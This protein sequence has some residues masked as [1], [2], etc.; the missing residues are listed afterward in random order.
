MAVTNDFAAS[1]LDLNGK[2]SLTQPTALVWGPDGRLYVSENGGTINVLTVAFGDVDPSDDDNT[3]SFYVEAAVSMTLDVQ[4]HN[5]DGTLNTSVA[6]QITGLEVTAQYDSSGNQLFIDSEGDLTTEAFGNTAAVTIFV[7]SSDKRIGAGGSGNDADLDT[8]SGVITMMTQDGQNSWDQVD[9]VRGLPRSEE[10]HAS[11]GME[12]IQELDENGVLV[13]ERLLLAQGGNANTGAPSNNFA[14]Q[15]EQPLSAAILEIDVTAIK[16]MDV[17]TDDDD[18]Q[19]VYDLPTLDDPTREGT[20]D[21]NDPNG[22]NDGLNSAILQQDGIVSIYSPGYRNAYDIEVT[23]D[24]RVWTYDNGA[25]NSWGGRPHGEAGDN[26]ANVDYEQDPNYI[27]TNLNNGDGYSEDEISL[28]SN[29][30]PSN[31]DNFHE[32][33]RSDDLDGREL[34]VGGNGPVATYEGPDGLTYVYGGHPNP[35]RASGAKAGI[36]FSPEGGTTNAFLLVSDQSSYDEGTDDYEQIVAW[37]S[38]VES[39]SG[40]ASAGDLTKKVLEVTPGVLYDIYAFEDG[41][42]AAVVAGDLAPEGGTL[43]GQSGLPENIDEIVSWTNEIEGNYLEA[44]RTDGALDT[45]KGSINGLAEYTSTIM[46][47]GDIKMSGAIFASVY[48]NGDLVIMGRNEDGTMSST[49]G[50]NATAAD[51]AVYDASGVPLGLATLGDDYA[52]LGLSQAFQGSVWTAVYGGSVSIQILQP[53]NG[54]VPLA[55]AEITDPND[56]DLDGI[57]KYH[58]PFEFSADNGFLLNP[59]QKIVL[60]FDPQS[61]ENEGS[62]G[63]NTGLLGAAL[64]GPGSLAGPLADASGTD[65]MQEAGA[66]ANQDARTGTYLENAGDLLG[67]ADQADGLYDLAGNI[68]PGGNAPIL[69]IKEVVPGTMVGAGNTARDAL[70]TG[71]RPN[72]DV[73]RI[74]ATLTANNWVPAQSVAE[75]QLVGMVFGDGTQ[76]NFL[77]LVFGEVNGVPGL[78]VGYEIDDANYQAL[79]QVALEDLSLAANALIDLR[80]EIDIND[81]YAVNAFYRLGDANTLGA[82]PFTV[83]NLGGFSLPEGVLQNVLNGTHTISDGDSSALSGASI[84]VVAETSEGNPLQAI[85]FHNI[86]IEAFGNEIDA[87]SAVE[88]GQAGTTGHDQIIYSGSDT[89]LTLAADVEDFDGSGSDA[90]FSITTNDL[91]NKVVVGSGANVI[92]TGDGE[93]SIVGTLA[94]LDGDEITDFTPS[95]KLIISDA[96]TN[97]LQVAYA[98][99][100][101]I[102]TINGTTQI[103]FSGPDFEDFQVSD[104]AD[105]FSFEDSAEGLVVSTAPAL[106]PVLAINA[107][108]AE[109]SVTTGTLRD[110][111]LEFVG[112]GGGAA[113]GSFWTTPGGTKSYTNNFAQTHDYPGTDLDAILATERSNAGAFG[114][115]VDV[116]DGT[117]LIDFLFAEIYHGGAPF[118]GSGGDGS[119]V[120]DL[121]VEGEE[122]FSNID[123]H[124]EA[125]GNGT[126]LIKSVMVEITDGQLNINFPSADTD[127]AKLSGMVI[128]SV[129][130]DFEPPADTTIPEIVSIEVNNPQSVQDGERIATVT[131]EDDTGFDAAS[132][133]R[134]DGTELVF[135]GIVPETISAPVVTL[136]NG[137]T[138][139]TLTYTLTAADN[140]WTSGEGSISIAPGTFQDAA[141]NAT[142]A[143]SGAFILEPGLDTLIKGNL[144]LAINVGPTSNGTADLE[145]DNDVTYGGAI[146]GDTILGIDLEADNPDYYS[147]SSKT[148]SNIDG[149]VGNTGSN[150]ALDGS[151]LHTYRD[152]SNGSF[153]ASYPIENGI[154]VVELWFAELYHETGG[155]RQGDYTIN[156]QPWVENFDA[157]TE[158]GGADTPVMISKTV[159]VTD[160]Q[161]A[162]DMNADSGQPGWNAIV[163]Y[164]AIAP[165]TPPT[166]SV[167][168][169]TAPEGH[170]A[171]V[172]FT[173]TG[174]DSEDVMVDF[175]VTP[176]S[177]D[178]EDFGAPSILSPVTIP[179]GQS[180]VQ[181][182]IPIIDDE[183]EEGAENFSVTIMSVSNASTDALIAAGTAT[184]T[185]EPSDASLQIPQ[186]GVLYELDFETAGDPL[187][188][189]GFDTLL[190]GTGALDTSV[191]TEVIDG[192]LIVNTSNGDLSQASDTASKNDFAKTVDLSAA[193]LEEI[194]LTTRFDN[195]FPAAMEAQGVTSEVIPNYAQQGIVIAVTDPT[196][197]QD[198]DN[199]VKLVFGG[200]SG[201]GVQMWSQAVVNQL[202][203]LTTI[204]DAAATGFGLMDIASI[205]LSLLIDKGDGTIAQLVTFYNAAGDILGGTRPTETPGFALAAPQAMPDEIIASI[206]SGATLAG[207]TSTD[208]NT[209]FDSFEASWDFLQITSPQYVE[210]EDTAGP[211]ATVSLSVPDTADGAIVVNVQYIDPSDIDPSTIDATDLVL[212]GPITADAPTVV[213]D[214]VTG[215]A[216]YTFAAPEGGWTEGEYTATL[217]AGEV[218]DL[219][220]TPNVSEGGQS[221]SAELVLPASPDEYTPGDVLHAFNFGGGAIENDPILGISFDAENL[222]LI[223][224][225]GSVYEDGAAGTDATGDDASL[226]GSIYETERYA[227]N[228]SI[229]VPVANGLYFIEV[230]L[231]E[232]FQGDE[233]ARIFDVDIE[234]TQAE[235]ALDLVA[236]AGASTPYVATQLVLVE[237]GSASIQL[238][239]TEDNAKIAGLVI[240]EAV[241]VAADIEISIEGP[242]EIAEDGNGEDQAVAYTLVASD[243]AFSGDVELTLTVDGIVMAQAASFVDGS[244]DIFVSVPTDS[245]WNGSETVIVEITS[246]ETDGFAI[247]AAA[248]TASATILENDAADVYDLDGSG[249]EAPVQVGDFSDDRLNPTSIGEMQIGENILQASQQGDGQPGDRDRDFITFEIPEGMVLSALYLDAYDS[250]SD[251]NAGFMGLQKG[252]QITVDPTT[253]E[254]D[255]PYGLDAGL[256][257]GTGYLT[258]D[259]LPLLAASDPSDNQE[260]QFPGFDLPLTAGTYTLWLNQG[261]AATSVTL[262]AVVEEAPENLAPAVAFENVLASLAEN[263]DTTVPIKV[264]DIVVTDDGLGEN[265]LSLTGADADLFEIVDTGTALELHLKADV[266]LDFETLSELSVSVS[267]DDAEIGTGVE[268]SALFT[269]AITDVV[270]GAIPVETPDDLPTGGTSGDDT[271]SYSGSENVGTTEAPYQMPED[272]ENFDATGTGS[273]K[274]KGTAG[275]NTIGLGSG[276]EDEVDLSDGGNDIVTG[277]ADELNNSTISGIASDDQIVV[278]GADTNASIIRVDEGS[279]IIQID[280]DGD[281]EADTTITLEEDFAPEQVKGSFSNGTFMVTVSDRVEEPDNAISIAFEEGNLASYSNQ[282]ETPDGAEILDDGAGLGLSG[283]TWKR[284]A[285][286][287]PLTIEAGMTLSLLFAATADGEITGIGLDDDNLHDQAGMPMFQFTGSQT[288]A[289]AVQD[290]NTYTAGDGEVEMDISL[291][292]WVGKTFS[293]LVFFADD[294]A[295]EVA[296]AT[297][298]NVKI[299]LP[300]TENLAPIT[301]DDT[302]SAEVNQP[303]TID[304]LTL[305]ANDSDPEGGALTLISVTGP[306]ASEGSVELAD[307]DIVFTPALDFSGETSFAYEV[308][309]EDG[310]TSTGNVSVT[311][312]EAPTGETV[313]VS[314]ASGLVT[315]YGATQDEEPD[316]WSSSNG[317]TVI[318]LTGN[319]WKKVALP[320]IFTVS[321]DAVLRFTVSS[322]AISEIIAIG[323]EQDNNHTTG[324]QPIFQ[325]AGSQL[326]TAYASQEFND[327]TS[328]EKTYEISFSGWEGASF[329]HLVLVNDADDVTGTNVTFS[330]VALIVAG[331]SENTAPTATDDAYGSDAGSTFTVLGIELT[332]NDADPEGDALSV[333]SVQNATNGTVSIDDDVITFTPPPGFKGLASFEYTIED[334][335][336]GTSTATA[337]IDFSNEEPEAVADSLDAT[338]DVPLL[339]VPEALLANDTDAEG[340]AL[341]LTGVSNALN[342]SVA[343][344]DG[345]ITFTP[346]QGYFGPASFDYTIED[347]FGGTS[348]NTVTLLFNEVDSGPQGIT[349]V[350]FDAQNITSFDAEDLSGGATIEDDG[351]VLALAG[352]TWKKLLL[353]EPVSVTDDMVLRFTLESTN[354]GEIIAIGLGNDNVFRTR[355]DQ[356]LFQLAGSQNWAS[357]AEQDYDTYQQGQGAVTYEI[358]LA[359]WAGQSFK[360]LYF[361]NDHDAGGTANSRY[362]NVQIVQKDITNQAPVAV[363]D[364]PFQVEGGETITLLPADLLA[365]D[366]DAEGDVLGVTGIDSSENGIAVYEDGLVY[367]TPDEG[368]AGTASFTYVIADGFGGTDTATVYL[369]VNS[370]PQANTDSFETTLGE[371]LYLTPEDLLANDTDADGDALTLES[372]GGAVGGTVSL[373]DGQIVF[374]PAQGFTGSASFEYVISDPRGGISTGSVSVTVEEAEVPT[375]GAIDIDFTSMPISGYA[376]PNDVTSE[377]YTATENS[378]SLEGNTWKKVALPQPYIPDGESVLRFEFSSSE[379]GEIMGIGLEAN[380]DFNNSEQVHF[381]LAGSQNWA[382]FANQDYFGYSPEDGTVTIE[383]PLADYAGMEFTYIVFINDDDANSSAQSTFSN[384]QLTVETAD[385]APAFE[386]DPAFVL[387]ENETLVGN[388]FAAD[389]EGADILYSITGGDDAG[390]F[391]I[392]EQTGVISFDEA[393]N[394]EFPSDFDGDNVFELTVTADDGSNTTSADHTVTVEDANEAP[395]ISG[396]IEDVDLEAGEATSIDLSTLLVEDEDAGS[397]PTIRA[398][399][400]D[401]SALPS[402]ITLDGNTLLVD[403]TTPEGSYTIAIFANDGELDSAT[404]ITFTVDVAQTSTPEAEVIYRINAF[405]PEVAAIDGGPNWSSDGNGSADNPYLSTT[406]SR[407]DTQGYTGS[408]AAIPDGV[409]QAVLDTARSSNAAFSY[410]IPVENGTYQVKIYV[411]ELFS[412][413]QGTNNRNFDATLEGV[414][415]VEFD[416]INP[417]G[418]YGADVGVLT[419]EVVVSDGVLDIGF[420]QDL[421]QNPIVNAIEVIRSATVV[422]EDNTPPVTAIS[423]ANPA[424]ADAP[425]M[426]EIALDDDSGID[427]SSLGADDLEITVSGFVVAAGVTFLGFEA[428]IANYEIAAPSGGWSEGT[429]VGVSLV[430][431]AVLDLAASPNGNDSITQSLTLAFGG[432]TEEPPVGDADMELAGNL[433]GDGLL[434]SADGDI[435]G[436]GVDNLNDRAA[437]DATNQG[438]ILSE[439]GEISF[440]FSQMADG[441]SPFAAGFTGV[442]QAADGTAELDYATNNGAQV[443]GGRLEIQTTNPDTKDAA[444][445]FTFLADVENDFTLEAVFDN[446]VYGGTALQQYSQYGLIIS[447]TGADG[448]STALTGDFIKLT[449]GNP[450]G[451]FELSGRGSFSGTDLKIEYPSGVTGTEFAQVKLSLVADVSAGTFTGS[452]E[453]LND[454]GTT[455]ASGTI[456]S[457]SPNAGSAMAGVLAGTSSIVPAFGVTSTDFGGG[458]TFTVGVSSI[459]LT[460]GTSGP[461]EPVDPPADTTDALAIL[462]ALD[463][464]D[465]GGSYAVGATGS[466]ELRVMEGTSNVQ[467]SNYGSSSFVLENTGDKQIAAVLIDFRN[468][469]YG[470]S[471]VDPDGAGGDNASKHFAINSGA[472]ETGAE[473]DTSSGYLF[474]GE[475]PL[476]NT[477][478]TGKASNGGYRGI[479]LKMDG[480]GFSNG[481]V[482]GFSGDMDPNSIAGLDKNGSDGVD[483]NSG[484]DVG[485]VSGAELIGSSFTVMFDDGT[486]ATGYLGGDGSQAG[487]IG[488]A[489]Q[490]IV[491]RSASVTVNGTDSASVGS[492][493]VT[494]PAIIV[495]GDPG[496]TVRVTLSRGIN[497]VVNNTNGVADLVDA[498][499]ADAHPEF[500]VS[501]AGDFQF[502]DV[503]I[504]AGGTVTLPDNAFDW[505][506]AD[507]GQSFGGTGYS[508]GFSTA[509]AVVGVSVIDPGS[510]MPLGS[511]NRVYLTNQGGPVTQQG[512]ADDGSEGFFEMIGSGN[513][514]RFKVQVEDANANGGAN[515]GGQWTY[516]EGDDPGTQDNTQGS[517]H[518]FWGP[519]E[520]STSITS[521]QSNSFLEYTIYIPEGEEGVWNFRLRSSRDT[522]SPSDQ[523][524]DIWLKIDDDAEALQVSSTNAVSSAGFVKLFGAST[525]WGWAQSI[526]SVSD[527][528]ANFGASFTLSAGYHTITLAGRSHG[529]HVDFWDLYKG[530]A[531]STGASNSTFV[532]TG[533]TSPVVVDPIEDIDLEIGMGGTVDASAAFQD[534]DGDDLT[535]VISAPSSISSAVS[536]DQ[537]TGLVT[538]GSGIA[539]GNYQ[540]TVGASDEDGNSVS[541]S[542]NLTVTEEQVL[543]DSLLEFSVLSGSTE[544]DDLLEDGDSFTLAELGDGFTFSGIVT[545]GDTVGS[546]FLEVLSGGDVVDSAMENITPYDVFWNAG[547]EAGDFT[548][549]ASSYSGGSGS[550]ELLA[551]DELDFTITGAEA[552]SG[553][554][555]ISASINNG[556]DDTDQNTNGTVNL[557]KSDLELGDSGRDI[558]L[559]YEGVDLASLKGMD[560]TGAY[561]QFT[562]RAGGGNVGAL[563]ATIAIQDSVSAQTFSSSEGPRDRDIF[564]FVEW[565]AS[566]IPVANQTF[567]SVDFSDMLEDFVAEWA[568]DITGSED[569]AFII[570]DGFGVRKIDSYE[571]GNAP[572]LII[573]YSDF[574]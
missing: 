280:T 469:L 76:S 478:G 567:Q 170:E 255:G 364:G 196:L 572:I 193:E 58:D 338:Q 571:A 556:T 19:Y 125:G 388:V 93:D 557:T 459:S 146:T 275:D 151:A 232:L 52:E 385:L 422:T 449:T 406:D 434:N 569:I 260:N 284:V 150:T 249:G 508:N 216:T 521:P 115:N 298:S 390:L 391:T 446:P 451:G 447:L 25:N 380:S 457:I 291:D 347:A 21:L 262:R 47:E 91:D 237:D 271:V 75:G 430:A 269:L 294:D 66:T 156:G 352:N 297:F 520:S 83:I 274:V 119:R 549:R 98:E 163:V 433:D 259:L 427:P 142:E 104:G 210:G 224:P 299:N 464:V 110:L 505:L 268:D 460:E 241:P 94:D 157:F 175:T 304:P 59:G 313:L 476:P 29:F 518:Y 486:F 242:G 64:D 289:P 496:D 13:S 360:Y 487:S 281:G 305:L 65:N 222:D 516:V 219:A 120:F 331:G 132:F 217:V 322:D 482:I 408:L 519:E 466:A 574:G 463:D 282:D 362:T 320:E 358:D 327:Y 68:I 118:P 484:W 287:N 204:S 12:M 182:I 218:S 135:V 187:S 296:A 211:S 69:Q 136:S 161:I 264:A 467:A 220:E 49:G 250:S 87:T 36:L 397:A 171:I 197:N 223:A 568:D 80:L 423:L 285:L 435:D 445:G 56:A 17:L 230:H 67:T 465:S 95:D 533:D 215:T 472:G 403:E 456:G 117:Y 564:D 570:E 180:F 337:V 558:G 321:A 308:Q 332:K 404:P 243:A 512:S 227:A 273:V 392:D 303:L 90:D 425:I 77:R 394:F 346:D 202:V 458:D 251:D 417:G 192:K 288:W 420:V 225:D 401:G 1:S 560:I 500:E 523:R 6:R 550:G 527:S 124:S 221:S 174:D 355:D 164:E 386:S 442:A 515:P 2:V 387:T 212:S 96:S 293:H 328:G 551:V 82:T 48:G 461:S 324:S 40:E 345:Q 88:V 207:V 99:G 114:Y 335:N 565:T 252:S 97:N 488:V 504:G 203:T 41:S 85:D 195:P 402:G 158:A 286:N 71:I 55:G 370:T 514:A 130:A 314:F 455:T 226:D 537:A 206:A 16:S 470:D 418:T 26:G 189:G 529:F 279:T 382:T 384:V 309:D 499:L 149:L 302:L 4:N 5:D 183:L 79:A 194:Y 517:G 33:T 201:T 507:G 441:T 73:G 468:A 494:I 540:I 112:D 440:D 525:G 43:I 378:L 311:V 450:G 545:T 547:L 277:T 168:G 453:L 138:V 544:I 14:G 116:P 315:S 531:P 555:V 357:Y 186:G 409:P 108:G 509:P 159:T 38:Q 398:E 413:F 278:E 179:A 492:Y 111:Q 371:P 411:A 546:V 365:N 139:A 239:A 511:V 261:G 295:E 395:V 3:L 307:G 363:D 63:G 62:I 377:G 103:T 18:R 495:S 78:E 8:N 9:I 506:N 248:A 57:D 190:G 477:T 554:G 121:E 325:L 573:E 301:E 42:G 483:P 238:S 552:P 562:T 534:L 471:V 354:V 407:G 122:V 539:V 86:E 234:G 431:G 35:T 246:I 141:G 353:D 257:Y 208:Y 300:T 152:S 188:E 231:I 143:S 200:N 53:N 437:Y 312:N 522:N 148:T 553:G 462:Q 181:V 253:G 510:N 381:Q 490:S 229:E 34:S 421:V 473:F 368:F 481:E 498:R 7:S 566:D 172:T 154:Y 70:H 405:G 503:V 419:A 428:G 126:L 167:S 415:P 561:L 129:G 228:L 317:D 452:Y 316:A 310:A 340:D 480:T 563:S 424:D 429:D 543:P 244:A 350:V 101:A 396:T 393:P 348:T 366:T 485:G 254:P 173:R 107:G 165:D 24:G 169:S 341:T 81:G 46:D 11:N 39:E 50:T 414:V 113:D 145:G 185:I 432:G 153:S 379:I 333:I 84:G 489:S 166:I 144:A 106:A 247:N 147:P 389:P 32:V 342:G 128:W 263:A 283:N 444:Q 240:R 123:I 349:D 372:V 448:A 330:D 439:V 60:D 134:L 369:T 102:V 265:T 272:I 443:S 176:G 89:E 155:N 474:A 436:D 399:L 10:N 536:I 532:A 31:N 20:E 27:A 44:G 497:P 256:I 373:E 541:D 205:E 198:Q 209:A 235:S 356:A 266:T 61:T 351:E 513:S 334:G 319:T 160:G 526:D 28:P 454:N 412:G 548:L 105:L 528:E 479:L 376:A 542:F 74:V 276:E 502:Y 22:G 214:E 133:E 199:L 109:G 267:V 343:F 326:W 426:V 323:L 213:F 306:D 336:G 375:R 137:D 23:E 270:E 184:V 524:N 400:Q 233:G 292:A 131:L 245:R 493:G 535:Y 491:E 329:S 100:S 258:G 92:T 416:N 54:A 374:T 367:F 177:A 290:Y 559:R 72:P 344:E 45:G 538:I 178:A 191:I 361:V 359:D 127:Q 501:N 162:I 410:N 530:T 236:K 339:I 51:R 475:D 438:V 318:E 383:I 15:Q 140:I 37:L 30:N